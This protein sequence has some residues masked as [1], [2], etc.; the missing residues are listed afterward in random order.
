[1][2]QSDLDNIAYNKFADG[3][4]TLTEYIKYQNRDKIMEKIEAM[5]ILKDFRDKSALFSV[6]TALDTI[7]PGLKGSKDE[8]VRKA[9]I[10]MVH[11]TTGDELWGDYNVHKEDALAWLEKQDEAFTRKDVDDAYLKGMC[12][13]K[14]ELEK[15][16]NIN[17]TINRDKLAQGVL[18]GAAINL[19]TWIDYNA[20]EG[21][22]CLS[23]MEC[24]DI[25]DALVS[26]NWDKIYAYIKKKL[27][28]QD[29][30]SVNIDIESMVSS[31]KQ[32]LKSQGGVE[33]S[34][35]VNMCLTA[36]RHGIENTLEELNL[37]ELE[38]Q[39]ESNP[40]SGV[41]FKYNGHTWGMCARDNGVDIL[42]DKQLFKHIEKQGEQKPTEWN[43]ED[44]RY[45]KDLVDYFT[46]GHPLKH[47]ED[48]ITSWLKSLK[49][50]LGQGLNPNDVIEW[51][52]PYG[53]VVDD[54]VEQFK[55]DFGL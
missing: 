6:R 16:G 17:E 29:N 15:Q 33:N 31:Y 2:A 12:D 8:K 47:D 11:D 50:R 36:F 13:T 49:Q 27:E 41:S 25:E 51:L 48:D 7:I 10:E 40:Y 9:L 34:P 14:H 20:A 35:L 37:K 38:K 28:K 46:A 55:E 19:I 24:K 3:E 21:N 23:N 44:E 30:K 4:I 45:V 42:L 5:K 22:M 18:R 43:E 54:I 1:M 53:C 52:K 26:G 39:G 32:R